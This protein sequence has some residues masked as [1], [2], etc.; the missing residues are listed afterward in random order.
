MA[1]YRHELKY[2]INEIEAIE[3][4][5]V[6]KYIMKPDEH[7]DNG[8]YNIRSL[9]FDDIYQ[10]AYN[11]KLDGVE[12]RK[13]Y[14]IRIYNCRDDVISLECKHKSG[15]YIYKESIKI[16]NEEYGN[17]LNG[18]T[19]FL[20]KKNS[21]MA[22]EFYIDCKSSILKP[23]VIVDYDREPLIYDVGT[24]RIT[25]DRH[26]R[27]ENSTDSIFDN[28][29]HSYAVFPDGTLILEVKFTELLPEKIRKIL[30]SYSFAQTSASKYC[31][32]LYRLHGILK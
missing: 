20:L 1:K 10:S 7:A 13:K 6:L 2:L 21:D 28:K 24:V 23:N 12:E 32:C 9:Y 11:E 30:N 4:S 19:D 8:V 26:V 17:I 31:L 27:A 5:N 25:F 14:R 16:S 22:R 29:I 15:Q 18:D 3:L